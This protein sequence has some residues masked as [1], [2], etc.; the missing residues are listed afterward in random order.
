M[1]SNNIF[2]TVGNPQTGTILANRVM[3]DKN[4]FPEKTTI[5]VAKLC[6]KDISTNHYV[7]RNNKVR[8]ANPSDLFFAIFLNA[9]D[10]VPWYVSKNYPGVPL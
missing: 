8:K 10:T 7:V 5:Q 1:N 2:V 9:N 3:L 4:V 6:R